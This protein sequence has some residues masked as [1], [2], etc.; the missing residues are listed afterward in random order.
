MSTNSCVGYQR[1]DGSVRA[2]YVHWDGYPQGVGQTLL[3]NHNSAREALRLVGLGD[4]SVLAGTD[5]TLAPRGKSGYADGY[6]G[7]GIITYNRWRQ[8]GTPQHGTTYRDAVQYKLDN[9]YGGI[10][11]LYLYRRGEGWLVAKVERDGRGPTFVNL[12][13]LLADPDK[14]GEF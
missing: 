10:E 11:Y 13:E 3:S 1:K 2:V 8:E 12:A 5:G 14:A 6:E 4:I 7:A 9:H